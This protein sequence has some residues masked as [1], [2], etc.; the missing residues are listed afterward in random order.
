MGN[1]KKSK[2]AQTTIPALLAFS[3]LTFPDLAGNMFAT[4]F[5]VISVLLLAVPTALA[6]SA[7]DWR[8]RAIYQ[9]RCSVLVELNT[10]LFYS[11][12]NRQVLA[13]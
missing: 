8:G 4:R 12:F 10:H 11:A 5:S 6:A 7:S 9:A 1:R 2:L 3:L 13:K